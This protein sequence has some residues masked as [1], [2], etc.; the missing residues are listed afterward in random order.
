[1]TS[2]FSDKN[3]NTPFKASKAFKASPLP[4]VLIITYYWPPGSGAGVQRWLKFAKYLPEFGWEPVILTVDPDYASFP[5]TDNTLQNDI[6]I[7]TRVFKTRATNYFR[8]Y[9]KGSTSV[10]SAGFAGGNEDGFKARLMRFIR[11]NFFIPDPRKGW[12]SYAFEKACELIEKEGIKHIITTSP[13]HSTQLI[14]LKL[15]KRY[16]EIKWIADLRDPWTDIYY[17]SQFYHTAPAR[18]IDESYEFNVLKKADRIITVGKSLKDLFASKLAG[19]E[20]KIDILTNGFDEDDFKGIDKINPQKFTISYIGTLSD[21]Y[22]VDAFLTACTKF[23]NPGNELLLRFVGT[24]SR[25]QKDLIISKAGSESVEFIPY[26]NHRYA[27]KYMLSSS[28]LLLIIPDHHSNKSII[29]GK[30]FEYLAAGKPIICLGP[31]DG[32]AAEI[33][34]QSALSRTFSYTESE[35]IIAYL[36]ILKNN[37]VSPAGGASLYSRKTLTEMLARILNL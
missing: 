4:K 17:Y 15:K 27:I 26:V 37:I 11:G 9:R 22:P 7:A 8:I 2:A 25:N 1:M 29:T 21:A 16:P 3:S 30:L 19:I 35:K 24:V 31:E 14:G 13:P 18:K 5:A 34:K 33:L 23:K 32:D 10:P 12:N 20:N 36:N 6:P 28:A